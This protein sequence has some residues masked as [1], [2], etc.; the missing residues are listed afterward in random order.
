MLM[1]GLN[2]ISFTYFFTI[3]F[4]DVNDAFKK[5]PIL[6]LILGVVLPF[7]LVVSVDLFT[8]TGTS[9]GFSSTGRIFY[10]IFYSLDPLMTFFMGLMYMISQTGKDPADWSNSGILLPNLKNSL[11]FMAG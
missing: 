1:F 4:S 6:M 10:Y 5:A 3:Y 8:D 2:L 11:I 7:G 9:N